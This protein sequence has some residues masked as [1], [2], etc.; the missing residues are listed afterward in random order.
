MYGYINTRG[1]AMQSRTGSFL[2]CQ[3]DRMC[4]Y[5][6][7][8]DCSCVCMCAVMHI[9]MYSSY[10][11]TTVCVHFLR[12]YSCHCDWWQPSL[13]MQ[14]P[15]PNLHVDKSSAS[16][17]CTFSSCVLTIHGPF[18]RKRVLRVYLAS[19]FSNNA[20]GIYDHPQKFAR[21]LTAQNSLKCS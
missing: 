7:V 5:V 18:D 13:C 3:F 19:P 1:L 20:K 2:L 9:Y 8:S 16:Y 10:V 17:A 21:S 14:L 15:L 12:I 4:V 11:L 6:C